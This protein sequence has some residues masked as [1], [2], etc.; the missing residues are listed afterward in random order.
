MRYLNIGINLFLM[1]VFSMAFWIGVH[2][3]HTLFNHRMAPQISRT[4]W[5]ATTGAIVLFLNYDLMRRL[6]EMEEED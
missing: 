5:I 4:V 3:R 2:S 6:Q 1:I